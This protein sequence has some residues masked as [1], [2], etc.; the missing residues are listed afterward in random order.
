MSSN[1]YAA[2]EAGGTKFICAVADAEARVVEETRIETA[3][4]DVTFAA[5]DSFFARARR[6]YDGFKGAGIGS[7]GPVDLD[8]SSETYGSIVTTPKPNWS[9]ADIL[10]MIRKSCDAPVLIDT[11]VNCAALAEG[12]YGATK[13]LN[14]HCY[15]TVGTGIGVGIV[16][17]GK[18]LVSSL[19]PEV[20]H[21][22]VPMAEDDTFA[23]ICPYHENC[24]EGLAC[25]PAMKERWQAPVPDLPDD[26]HAWEM[27]AYYVAI[28]CANLTYTVRPERIV[29]GGGVFGR[30]S[31]YD[32]VR[33]AFAPMINGYAAGPA[34]DPDA[35]IVPPGVTS[36]SP[37]LLGAVMLAHEAAQEGKSI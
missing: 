33:K 19:H 20:G 22:R 32:R 31:L 2:I 13:G 17:S 16:T 10:G 27:E 3:D 8:T 5:V 37:G 26:H 1:Y 28:L 29:I 23:G 4:P 15:I 35:Y 7:F 36:L 11:D 25:G 6:K 12:T 30:T 24:L 18:P 21:M 14:H 34:S 9:N